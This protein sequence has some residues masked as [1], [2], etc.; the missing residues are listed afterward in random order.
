MWVD[1]IRAV[2]LCVLAQ[3]PC[4]LEIINIFTSFLALFPFV[5]A[6]VFAEQYVL[7]G[8]CHKYPLPEAL[9]SNP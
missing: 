1:L 2:Y 9:S 3:F 6:K 5:F 7:V 4:P 8:V